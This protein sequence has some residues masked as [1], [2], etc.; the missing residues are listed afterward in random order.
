MMTGVTERVSVHSTGPQS[1]NWCRNPSI[2][3]DGRYVTF[4][5]YAAN[6]VS[7]DVNGTQDVFLHDRATGWTSLVSLSS[8]G[9]QANSIS[10]EGRIT[11]DGR[12]VA[13]E[14]WASNLVNNDTNSAG[15]IFLRDLASWRVASFCHGDGNEAPCPCGHSRGLHHGCENSSATSRAP[16]AATGNASLGNDTLHVTSQG[17]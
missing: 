15:D 11:P 3:A 13:F 12:F 5:S 17:E 10:R 16:L 6:L 8:G 7:G 2:S 1:S 14:S 4:D 9:T